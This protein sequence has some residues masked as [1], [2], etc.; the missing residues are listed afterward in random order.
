MLL[1]VLEE[2]LKYFSFSLRR[3]LLRK[4]LQQGGLFLWKS[5]QYS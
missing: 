5:R 4:G 1:F 2:L 3:E